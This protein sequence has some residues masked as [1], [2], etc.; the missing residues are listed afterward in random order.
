MFTLLA[1]RKIA[2]AIAN[3]ELDGLPGAGRPL[4][5]DDDSLIPE[6]LRAAYRILRNAGYIPPEVETLNQ[7]SQLERLVS[8]APDT[9]GRTRILRK[10]ALLRMAA[11]AR[12]DRRRA[13]TR[14]LRG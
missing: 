11:E 7:I 8:E 10:L 6:D 5:L 14:R 12:P 2:E 4:E 13:R 9:D 1:E 3:G